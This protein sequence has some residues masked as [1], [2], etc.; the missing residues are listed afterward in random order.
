[1]TDAYQHCTLCPRMCG[2]DRTAGQTGVCGM[3]DTLMVGRAAL[4]FW[5]E[6][7]LSG[8]RGSGTVF[9]SGCNLRCVFC[10]N[11]ALSTVHDGVPITAKRLGE[12]FSELE[13]QGA[14]NINLVTPT[15]YVPHIIEAINY[16]YS[17]HISIPFVYNCG[18]YESVET[19]KMLDGLIDIYLPDCKY[20][21]PDYAG[22][23]SS[24]RNYP[25]VARAAIAE[26]VRQC[27]PIQWDK[28]GMMR[29]GVIVRHLMLP[30]RMSET[31]EILRDLHDAYGDRI[32]ISL[33]NQYTPLPHCK[34]FPELCRTITAEEYDEA[35][36][37]AQRIGIQNAFIQE[38]GT[39]K[40]S[41]IPLFDGMGCIK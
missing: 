12:I 9:F 27:T 7:C 30:G 16:A 21:H 17:H 36:S 10:Q 38:G 37:F 3:T 13:A 24:A 6:P 41:F 26:M 28:D 14:H 39:Q 40:E 11:Y 35:V 8:S 15:H 1:M 32:F 18:G 19:L 2:V 25:E 22:R 5:E 4:H 33:M 23:Y 31:K 20:D 34:G 29:R